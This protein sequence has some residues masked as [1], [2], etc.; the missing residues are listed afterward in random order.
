[1]GLIITGGGSSGRAGFFPA[2]NPYPG[3]PNP[4][5]LPWSIYQDKPAVGAAASQAIN[6]RQPG[7]G[8]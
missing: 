7:D 2:V 5:G 8:D 4:A 6:A 1:M 3:A